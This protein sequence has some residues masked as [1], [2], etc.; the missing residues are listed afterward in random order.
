ML[1][2]LNSVV[3]TVGFQL[4]EYTTDEFSD[5]TVC[6]T[7]LSGFLAPG[8]S[9]MVVLSTLPGNGMYPALEGKFKLDI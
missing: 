2:F 4:Q 5:Q 1:F 3:V 7:V 9:V 8:V 6:L